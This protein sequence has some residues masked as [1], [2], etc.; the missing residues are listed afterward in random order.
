MDCPQCSSKNILG[1]WY[2]DHC[3]SVLPT[4][5][6]DPVREQA[7]HTNLKKA[8][9]F[10]AARFQVQW[11]YRYNRGFQSLQGIAR[12]EAR[13][14]LKRAHKSGY[15][16]IT[17]RW[18]YDATFRSKQ[19]LCGRTRDTMLQYDDLANQPAQHLDI[20]Y[21]EREQ[22]YGTQVRL[23][24]SGAGADTHPVTQAPNYQHMVDQGP[25]PGPP[26]PKGKGK[27]HRRRRMHMQGQWQPYYRRS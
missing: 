22:R 25:P 1:N 16:N 2:C 3:S 23:V 19:E 9:D 24:L 20:S 7:A 5:Y 17:H 26:P 8:A 12:H 21:Q 6:E 14:K 27:G 13:N 10:Y 18:D 15:Q 4:E 11:A